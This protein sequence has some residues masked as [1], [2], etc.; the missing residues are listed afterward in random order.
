[1]NRADL[2]IDGLLGIGGRG[3]L[4]EPFAGLARQAE[5]SRQAGAT[6]VAVDLPSGIDADTGA[7]DGPAVRADVTVTFGVIKPGLLIDPGAGH[8]GAV[9][10]IDIGLGPYL[11]DGPCA[12]APQRDDIAELLPRPRAESDKY[13]RGVLGLLAGSDRFTGAVLLSAGGAVR[14]GAG[15][16]R[17]VT[18]NVAAMLVRQAWPETVVTVHPDEGD[19]DLLGSVGRVQAWVAGPGMG[20]GQDAV[21]RLAAVLGTDLPVLVDADG[22]TILSQVKG[23]LPREAPTLITPHAGELA[24]LLGTDA[25]SVEARRLEHARRAARRARRHG[26]AEGFDDGDRTVRRFHTAAGPGEPDRHA[27]AGHCGQRRCAVR[28]GRGAARAGPG[29]RPGRPG[30]RLPARHGRPACRRRADRPARRGGRSG[31]GKP[32]RGWRGPDRGLEPSP[33]AARRL[34]EPVSAVDRQALVDLGAI[35][36]NVAALCELVRGSQVMAVVKASGY[37]H[38]MVPAARAALAGGASWLG[39]ADLTE[40][41]A[42]REAGITAPVLCLMTF[43]DPTE[44]IRHGV[45]LTA[46]S[47]AFAAKIAAAANRVG[48]RA[49]LHLKADTGLSRGGATAAEWPELIRAALAAEA[50]GSV[51]VTGLWSHFACADIPGHPSVAAQLAAFAERR[52]VRRERPASRPRS[53]TSPTPPPR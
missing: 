4:R 27:V 48:V 36:G 28:A 45:D 49:R 24:R 53:G 33:G 41:V 14:G 21:T 39:V 29:A 34:Q 25:A 13:R 10:L 8:A 2:I 32:W 47:V 5:Q 50:R 9:E 44:A 18:A 7:V 6:V 52:R 16:V 37:G 19:W 20:T 42:L 26:L 1:M 12:A 17:V 11:K 35:T 22:L 51:R 40:A 15:M 23:L 43:G 31:P 46:G 3:G 30:G 38:G